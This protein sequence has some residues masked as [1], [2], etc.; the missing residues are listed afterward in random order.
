MSLVKVT[1]SVCAFAAD[2]VKAI[3]TPKTTAIAAMMSRPLMGHSSVTGCGKSLEAT[4]AT[5]DK[6]EKEFKN[7][8]SDNSKSKSGGLK[9]DWLSVRG[10]FVQFKTSTFGFS[11]LQLVHY[12]IPPSQWAFRFTSR[13]FPQPC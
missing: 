3:P 5:P 10:R 12:Q 6:R 8:Q 9:L 1:A 7:G 11:D 2:V 4:R 13:V